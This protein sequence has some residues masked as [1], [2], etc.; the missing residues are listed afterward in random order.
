MI[1]SR[2]AAIRLLA[3]AFS[4]GALLGGGAMLLV[5][6]GNHP[7][8]EVHGGGREGYL[9]RLSREV[10]LTDDQRQQV[11][12]VLDR[13][14]P[15]MD[16]MWRSVRAPFDAERQA[17]RREIRA[18]LTPGQVIKYDAMIARRDSVRRARDNQNGNR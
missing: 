13:H 6:R 10:E 18:V 7:P 9:A 17:V 14:E 8:P 2:S 15:V 12:Q 16:S 4:L 11:T 5:D 3:L 1:A